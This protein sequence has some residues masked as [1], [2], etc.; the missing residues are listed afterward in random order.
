M[1]QSPDITR[2]L[3][4]KYIYYI[5]VDINSATGRTCSLLYLYNIESLVVA[6]VVHSG[7]FLDIA[8]LK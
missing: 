5:P 2:Y 6:V 4:K 3:S 1:Y 7:R 8:R